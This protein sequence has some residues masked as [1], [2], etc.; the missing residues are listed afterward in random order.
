MGLMSVKTHIPLSNVAEAKRHAAVERILLLAMDLV[1]RQG[2]DVTMDEIA[3]EVGVGR[4]TLF[5][6]F[7]SRERLLAGAIESALMRYGD[8]LP[9]FSGEWRMWLRTMCDTTHEMQAAY[10]R[11]YWD[12]TTRT[13]LAPEIAAVEL[14]RKGQR[15]ETMARIAG[16][17]WTAA[18]GAGD[19]PAGVVAAVGAHLSARFTTAVITD[20]GH[21]WHVASDL[22]DAAIASCIE[23]ELARRRPLA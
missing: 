20:V 10:G 21:P 8:Q 2:L 6:H 14:R 4:S 15:R 17:L 3:D 12:L 11:G 19:T 18:G 9:P 22:A 7:E 1:M 13:D 23:A 5:R 16:R